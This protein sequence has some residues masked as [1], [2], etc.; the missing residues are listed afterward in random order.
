M[1]G[2]MNK[3]IYRYLADRKWREY[4]RLVLMQ[5]ITQMKVIPDV[6]PNIDPTVDVKLAFVPPIAFS[7]RG[8]EYGDLSK[9]IR[10]GDFSYIQPGDFV[11]SKMSENPC[12]LN[13]QS[14]ER[15]ERLVSVAVIDSDVPN[16][17]KD[18]FDYR[19]HFLASNITINPTQRTI[20]LSNLSRSEQLLLP[21]VPPHAQKGSPYHRLSVLVFQQK[22]NIPVDLS[23]AS[24]HVKSEN[25]ILRSF[26][27]RHLLKPIGVH[28]FRTKWDAGT[29][30]VMQ[31][32]GIEGADTELKRIKVEPL[33]YKRRNPT[34]FR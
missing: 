2:D 3:P 12:W 1:T 7:R 22:D 14:F 25:F 16:L 9:G 8:L 30:E 10:A 13:V 18:G 11:D 15:G 27:D 28:L 29:A 34:S 6:I 20:N 24:K 4:R 5:R 32:A 23:V 33:P 21:W 26:I 31:R 19:C 17:Q